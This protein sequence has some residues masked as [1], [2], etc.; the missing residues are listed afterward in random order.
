MPK[1]DEI[2]K[3]WDEAQSAPGK[4]RAHEALEQWLRV[5]PVQAKPEAEST[6]SRQRPGARRL[7]TEATLDLHGFRMQEAILE[8]DRFLERSRTAGMRKVLI[9]H[10]KGHHSAS[11]PILKQAVLSHLQR[12]R[13]AGAIGTPGREEGGSGAVWVMIRR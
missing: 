5:N 11:G 2:L 3:Q 7:P 12:H 13:L 8:I 9:V 10:G 6:L 4:S 1:F